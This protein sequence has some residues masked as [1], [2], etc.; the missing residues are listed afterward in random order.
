ML[1]KPGTTKKLH[2][3][4]I[5]QKKTNWTNKTRDNFII[6]FTAVLEIIFIYFTMLCTG[7]YHTVC[8]SDEG[9]VHS[10][11]YNHQGQLGIGRK[12][13]SI[14]TVVASLPTITRVSCGILF[15]ICLDDN[16]KLWSFGDNTQGQLGLPESDNYVYT[17]ELVKDIPPIISVVC[18]GRHTLCISENEDLWTFGSN[19]EGQAFSTGTLNIKKPQKT[20][21]TN[22]IDICAGTEHSF[23]KNG[24][25][26]IFGSGSNSDG[27]LGLG[28]IRRTS[29]TDI[30]ETNPNIFNISSFCC[31]SYHSV[32]LSD[33]GE[34]FL[35]GE[36]RRGQLG[37]IN[38]GSSRTFFQLKGLPVIDNIRCSGYCTMCIDENGEI[39]V[40]GENSNCQLGIF[41]TTNNITTPVKI[42]DLCHVNNISFGFGS[43]TIVKESSE[44]SDVFAFGDNSYGQLGVGHT[45]TTRTKLKWENNKSIVCTVEKRS[46]A[47]SARK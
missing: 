41:S 38:A 40:F 14:P 43:H 22:V 34:V 12:V 46:F 16:G 11:G 35:T 33:S 32:F 7:K 39:W 31:G 25:D 30:L 42:S 19:S 1:H 15:T 4:R 37:S 20:G 24:S 36:N 47:K 27:Q 3:H 8:V 13:V 17:P 45:N 6:Y 21:Y 9:V 29:G 5:V 26:K 44:E 28:N 10:F 2:A 23:I 18:G